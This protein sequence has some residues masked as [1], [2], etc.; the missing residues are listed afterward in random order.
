MIAPTL[1]GGSQEAGFTTNRTDLVA[2][3][4]HPAVS[5]LKT[6][7]CQAI[8][9]GECVQSRVHIPRSISD[10]APAR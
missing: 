5:M 4:G 8:D 6:L 10:V 2:G 1:V 9:A 3:L 7:L